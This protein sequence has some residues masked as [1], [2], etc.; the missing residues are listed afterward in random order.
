MGESG[1]SRQLVG[2]R[3]GGQREGVDTNRTT[4]RLCAAGSRVPFTQSGVMS[5]SVTTKG[6]RG[7]G[8]TPMRDVASGAAGN[9]GTPVSL[10][11]SER[12]EEVIQEWLAFCGGGLTADALRVG[13]GSKSDV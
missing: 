12:P 6:L 11:G 1:L 8:K 2:R 9:F 3:G 10:T 13:K 4:V 7:A 5:R